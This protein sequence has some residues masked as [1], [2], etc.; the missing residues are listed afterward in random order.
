MLNIIMKK[1]GQVTIFIIAGIVIVSAV[2]LFFLF[3]SGVK[4]PGIGIGKETSP[5][6]FLELCIKDKVKEAVNILSSQGGYINP[7]LYKSFK[8]K[9]ENLPI[10][11]S[12]LCYNQANY[13]PCANQEP[14][15]IKHLEE[16]IYNYIFDYVGNCFDELTSSLDKQGYSVDTKYEGFEIDLEEKKIIIDIDGELILTKSGE[17]TKQEDFRV[18]ISSRLYDLSLVVQ[19]IINKEATTCEFNNYDMSKYREFNINKYRT[20]DSSVIYK[21]KHEDSEEEFRFAVRG[22]V[23]P[24]GFGLEPE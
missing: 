18:I 16:E 4:I 8:F 6:S 11:I 3:R 24:P 23:M 20:S 14:M 21:V 22:C 13:L 2:L 19:E 7:S 12:Y 17:T 1:G 5:P 15:L 10:N 9:D